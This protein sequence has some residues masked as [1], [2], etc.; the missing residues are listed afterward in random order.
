MRARRCSADSER[1]VLAQFRHQHF[2]LF[3]IAHLQ[4]A[5][6]LMFSD[7]LVEAL[8]RLDIL[9]PESVRRFKRVIRQNFE[10]FLR[11]THR[12][13][14][15][16]LS[17]QALIKALFRMC[18]EHLGN[19]ALYEEVKQEIT[20]MSDLSRQRLVAAPGQHRG[21]PDRGDHLRTDRHRGHRLSRHE[22]DRRSRQSR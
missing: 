16:E 2:L 10:M 13:W 19:D 6:L 1:G 3:L 8:N 20:D 14:F 5:A 4:K 21:A 11:F 18:T 15:H 22:P 9:D 7:R 12:Y 17:E